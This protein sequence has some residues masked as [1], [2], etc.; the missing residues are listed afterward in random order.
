[1]AANASHG[2]DITVSTTPSPR[3]VEFRC[4]Q[5]GGLLRVNPAIRCRWRWPLSPICHGSIAISNVRLTSI[6]WKNSQNDQSRKSRFRGP[7]LICAGN[8]REEAHGRATRGKIA[9]AAEALPNC[10]SRPSMA[11]RIV[12]D[13][14]KNRVRPVDVFLGRHLRHHQSC[15]FRIEPTNAVVANDKISWIENVAFDEIK[16]RSINPW[17]L[18]LH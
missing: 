2:I 15:H 9:R 4:R 8:R 3:P 1:M 7:N 16:H 10:P 6:V 18:R 5:K 12:I 11:V 17:S 14:R 13:A